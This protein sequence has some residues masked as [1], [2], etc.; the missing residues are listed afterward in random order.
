MQVV[1]AAVHDVI[2][3]ITHFSK[4]SDGEHWENC[5]EGIRTNSENVET[6]CF[7]KHGC[8]HC[9]FAYL[10]TIKPSDKLTVDGTLAFFMW[11]LD[12]ILL[13]A[14]CSVYRKHTHTG[15]NLNFQSD[16]WIVSLSCN[17]HDLRTEK[18]RIETARLPSFFIETPRTLSNKYVTVNKYIAN[19]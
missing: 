5:N 1:C 16:H 6:T 4:P 3:S 8:V 14:Y 2:E 15:K 11:K 10:N 9:F 17:D 12:V 7:F 19:N 13:G 18:H